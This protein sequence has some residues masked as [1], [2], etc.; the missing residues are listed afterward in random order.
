MSKPQREC[1][2]SHAD[3]MGFNPGAVADK[4]E[5]AGFVL[6]SRTPVRLA[7]EWSSYRDPDGTT[8]FFQTIEGP[9]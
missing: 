9:E 5:A 4:L 7:G 3:M 1:S 6:L 8:R 2:V